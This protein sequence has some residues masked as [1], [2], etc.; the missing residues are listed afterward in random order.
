MD[1]GILLQVGVA[2]Y[3]QLIVVGRLQHGQG[4]FVHRGFHPVGAV[5][6]VEN[7]LVALGD[8]ARGGTGLGRCLGHI[9][10]RDPE[11]QVAGIAGSEA[12]GFVDGEVRQS[13]IFGNLDGGRHE[14][15]L[16]GIVHLVDES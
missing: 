8:A 5:E 7:R 2:D 10:G 6:L 14:E 13:G 12:E 9:V 16:G 4:A 3:D 15:R 11:G 1:V